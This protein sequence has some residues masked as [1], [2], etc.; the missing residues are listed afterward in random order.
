MPDEK[1][2]GVATMRSIQL[3]SRFKLYDP[4]EVIEALRENYQIEAFGV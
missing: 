1:V 3:S 2:G 4:E